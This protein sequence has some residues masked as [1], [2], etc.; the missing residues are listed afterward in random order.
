[1]HLICKVGEICKRRCGP[2][3]G[4]PKRIDAILNWTKQNWN[5]LDR[6]PS[7]LTQ[8]AN[9]NVTSVFNYTGLSTKIWRQ[10][11]LNQRWREQ[12][13]WCDLS[14]GVTFRTKT[15]KCRPLIS[16]SASFFN[17]ALLC[18][19]SI[20]ASRRQGQQNCH[21]QYRFTS[22]RGFF[23]RLLFQLV[24]KRAPSL[25]ANKRTL[26]SPEMRNP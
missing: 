26:P 20:L 11:Q 24:S 25:S 8:R 14:S 22:M 23:C 12:G 19:G 21:W 2:H 18:N 4:I 16:P 10:N 13:T 3:M 9:I 1:M 5:S 17:K 6:F 15:P 7:K